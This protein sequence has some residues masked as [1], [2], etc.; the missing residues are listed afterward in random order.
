VEL[1]EVTDYASGQRLPS[2]N[3]WFV[4]GSRVEMCALPQVKYDEVRTPYARVFDRCTPSLLAFAIEQDAR[5]FMGKFGGSLK[6]IDDL[7]AE[8]KRQ[9]QAGVA[10]Q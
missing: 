2:A 6:R 10:G 9:A 8:R 7:M 5:E 1:I 3:A 4:E